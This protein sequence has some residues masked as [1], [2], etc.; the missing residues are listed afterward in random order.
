M[1]RLLPRVKRPVVTY[2]FAEGNH[3]RAEVLECGVVNRFKR[4]V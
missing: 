3:I 2:G 1:Q 4:C